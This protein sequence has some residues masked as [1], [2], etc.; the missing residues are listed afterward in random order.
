MGDNPDLVVE[1]NRG[2]IYIVLGIRARNET[3]MDD[4]SFRKPAVI[5]KVDRPRSFDRSERQD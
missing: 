3:A 1:Q 5:Q 2:K 4:A